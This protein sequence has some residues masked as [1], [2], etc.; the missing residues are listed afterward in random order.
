MTE[1]KEL[2]LGR[3]RHKDPQG[4]NGMQASDVLEQDGNIGLVIEM[5]RSAFADTALENLKLLVCFVK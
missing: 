5:R 1:E 2:G 4:E 3:Q